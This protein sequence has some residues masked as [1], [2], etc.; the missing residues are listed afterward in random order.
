MKGLKNKFGK[1]YRLLVVLSLAL[2]LILG[3]ITYFIT[4]GDRV[5]DFSEDPEYLKSGVVD[6]KVYVND[7]ESTYNYYMGLNYTDNDGS[8]PT[9]VNK[10]KYTDNNLVQVKITYSSQDK[11]NHI[12]YVS[13]TERQDTFVYFKTFYVNDNG[14]SDKSD[15]YIEIMLIDNPFTDRPQNM[16]FNGW[17][18]SYPGLV[19]SYD[20]DYY[21]RY[22]KV[23]VT[24]DGD[25]PKKIDVSFNASWVVAKVG[26]VTSSFDSA[27]NSLYTIGMQ[28]VSTVITDYG[29]RYY[30]V[31]IS[32]YESY[33][34]YYNNRGVYQESG[35]CRNWNGCTYY[36]KITGDNY[37]DSKDYYELVNGYMTNRG[38]SSELTPNVTYISDYQNINMASFY[39]KVVIT[40]GSSYA[41]YYNSNGEYQNSGT[42]NSNS[43]EYYE[44][45]QYYDSDGNEEISKDGEEY[46]Y[47]VTRDTNILVLTQD[48]SGGWSNNGSY[49]FTITG[50]YNQRDYNVD[51]KVSSAIN[52][53]NDT[54][55]ENVT[56]YYPYN[57]SGTYNPPTNTNTAGVLYGRYNNVR[58]GRGI[59][60][61]GNYYTFRSI[62]FGNG[63]S[64][65]GSSNSPA[66]YRV[67]LESGFYNSLSLSNG[68]STNGRTTLYLN[69][70]TEYGNDYDRVLNNDSKLDVYYCASSVWS[71]GSVYATTRS[72]TTR[73][74][75]FDVVVKSGTFGRVRSDLTSGIYVGGRYGGT[76]Y[77][78]RQ[79]K[80]LG[81]KIF[82][83]IG[84][85]LSASQRASYN[86]IYIYMLGGTVDAIT[87][88]AGTSATYGNR[89]VQV[90]GG[91]VNYAIFGG[92]NGYDGSD[93]DGTLRGSSYVYVGG[94]AIIGNEENMSS[95]LYGAEAG[96]VFGI[97]N[98]NSAAP[99]IGSCDNSTVIIDGKA[100]VRGNVYGGGNYGATGISSTTDSSSTKIV[101]NN[102][103]VKGSVYG[104]GNKNGSGDTSKRATV[105]IKMYNGNVVGSI[106]GG[107]N[108]EG[109]IYGDVNLSVLGGEVGNSVYGGGRGGL[110]NNTTGTYVRNKINLVVGDIN[111]NYTPI[112]NGAVY[113]GSAFGTVNGVTNNTTVSADGTSVVINKGII[114]SVYG[115]GQGNSEYTPYVLGNIEVTVNDGKITS[116][117]GGNDKSGKPNGTIKVTINGGVIN[118]AFGGGNETSAN[119][120][121]VYLN[122]GVSSKI[123]GGSNKSGDVTASYVT[124]TGGN[125]TYIYGGNNQGG[126][127]GI[128]NVLITGGNIGAVFGGGDATSVNDSTNV[129]IK[130]RVGTVYGG[131]NLLGTVPVANINV[132]D[133]IVDDLYGG[134]NQ[135]GV[136]NTSNVNIYG[137]YLKNV[138]GGGNKATTEVTNINGYYGCVY[139]IYGGGMEAGATTTNINLGDLKVSNVYGGA[140]ISGVVSDA[141][142]KNLDSG[143]RNSVKLDISYGESSQHNSQATNYKSSQNI[144]VKINNQGSSSI[145]VWDLY[146][147]TSDG[148]VGSNWSSAKVLDIPDGYYID[149]T[150]QYYGTNVINANGELSFDFHIHSQVSYEDFM[151][152]GYYF[153]GYDSNN[154]KYTSSI[155]IGNI[156]GGNNEGGQTDN[157]HIELT[158]G[159]IGNIYGGGNKAL[160]LT[161]SVSVS[162]TE[163]TNN[164]FGG[165][166]EATVNTVDMVISGS[167]IGTEEVDGQ[168]YGG[169]NKATVNTSIKM[170]VND[171]TKVFGS[172]YGGGN[173]GSV[174]GAIEATISQSEVGKNVYGGGNEAPVTGNILLNVIDNSK[175]IDSVYGGGNLGVVNGTVTT[176]ITDSEITN[177]IYGAGNKATVGLATLDF[178][179]DMV[180]TNTKVTNIYGGGNAALT[181][182]NVNV[183]VINST[184]SGSIFG[185]G[186]GVDSIVTGD[187][188]GENNLAKVLGNTNVI[189]DENTSVNNIYGGGNLGMV[190]GNTNVRCGKIRVLD[191]IY[192]G[193]NAAIVGNDTYLL[194]SNS[195]VMNSV[196]AGG[197]GVTAKVWGNTKIDID[198]SSNITNHVFG[199][200]NAA[201]TG[202]EEKNNSTGVVNI[203]GANI[204]KNV[205][206]GANTSVLYGM[207]KVNIGKD[208]VTNSD[209][210][211]S[212]IVIGGTVFGGGEANAGGSEI[213]DFT[214]ISV[215]KGID[216]NIDGNGYSNFTIGGSIFG[217]GN[218]SSTSGDSYVNIYNYGNKDDVKRNISIQ[219]AS[220]VTL[221]NS[222]M[223]LSGAT[224]RTNEYSDVLFTLSRIDELKLINSSSIYL[225]KGA[226]LVKKFTSLA[227]VDGKQEKAVASI[228]NDTGTFSRNVN[229]RV[230]M[231]SGENLNIAKNENV[232]DYGD[233]TGMTFFGMYS[234]DRN[235]NIITALY[236]DYEYNQ[237]VSSGDI[238]YF[239][240]GSYVLGRHL[241][242]HNITVDG[243]YSNYGN[244][245]GDRIIIKYIEP[246][247]ADS[248]FYMWSIGEVIASYEV[249]LTASKFS[250]LGTQ[251]VPLLNHTSPNTTFSILGVN[252]SELDS[253][254][255]LIDYL[256]I[257]RVASSS[258]EANT[259]FGLT[260]KS[261]PVGWLT[262]G[263]TNFI[264]DGNTNVIGTKQYERE[265]YNNVPAFVFYLYHSKNLTTTGTMGSVTVSLVAITPIDDLN[266]DVERINININLSRA[267]YNTNDYEGTIAPGKKYEMFATSS[268]DIT[269][270]SSFS[271]YYSLY[272]NSDVSP[273]KSGYYRSLVSSIVFPI[274]TKITMI[275]LHNKNRPIY[276]YYVVNQDDYDQAMIEYNRYSEASYKLSRFVK[277]G[278]TSDDNNYN[279]EYYNE[280]YYNNKIAEEEFIFMV[281]F[282]NANISEDLM[283]NSLLIELRNADE[284][285]L[286]SVLG[287]EQQTLKYNLYANSEAVIE[288]EGSISKNPLYLG[289][290]T[291]MVIDTNFV[292]E[293]RGTNTVYDTTFD[294]EKLGIKISIFDSHNNLLSA[295]DLMGISFT[296]NGNKYY[297][298][299]DGTTRIKI[300][301]KVANARSRI[302]FDTGTSKIATGEY[303][304]LVE[305]FGSYDGVYYGPETSKKLEMK[306]NIIDSPYGLKVKSA[307]ESIFIDKDSGIVAASGNNMYV[308]RINYVSEL[309]NANL[310]VKLKR[311]NYDNIYTDLYDDVNLL[312]YISN[313]LSATSNKWEYVLTNSPLD[314][315][316][317]NYTFKE[318]LVT[319]TYKLV[320][321]LYD[322]NNYIGEV[323][324]YIIIK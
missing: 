43:C 208:V 172:V 70:M 93:G 202:T 303:T 183:K 151:I 13:L 158:R 1:K 60:K 11:A 109:T 205:Y 206:G 31:S 283:N 83:L 72:S 20:N 22:A 273:Y 64:N 190:S 245:D 120:T 74:V 66:K 29:D 63:N 97:G 122:G 307:G 153:V 191:S 40:R 311:R 232:T 320:V 192:G 104:G 127:T 17:I 314:D 222:Y 114:E 312:D 160:T 110:D 162:N 174:N 111:S 292:Q 123:F 88:G 117:Y 46:Y 6:N 216:I 309:E 200:G 106:Y 257:P 297:P 267:L 26:M 107:S 41:G 298:R 131:S 310:R 108:E 140:N 301:D 37:S 25:R 185:G 170:L 230:Y 224:D 272:I 128:T 39:R 50:V 226:N 96:S 323:Y 188:T 130:S 218:A 231:E 49:P 251:E 99:T 48:I 295:Q 180:V 255:K 275:D 308:F 142:I 51:W 27:I 233:V 246:T 38:S 5:I 187:E 28:Q 184:L 318:N 181:N 80:V 175:V 177:N 124:A 304:I 115:G 44:M 234:L 240:D 265:N 211:A 287:I 16:A 59:N 167:K 236:D 8:Y 223:L 244:D 100:I 145:N 193:G 217:S 277:M 98:G 152:Y 171:N 133:G 198:N 289:K 284:Q 199:G 73:E 315:V 62:V 76:Q 189:V 9:E 228:D 249:N 322:G 102:G 53:Y 319:G 78:V 214:F 7:L 279:D 113:G 18:S 134:N 258:D 182:N 225:R 10:N 71:G 95:L 52:C 250:T 56:M 209:L 42:C 19:L 215:T 212:D 235:G 195:V 261:G 121:Y 227:L 271:T 139:N 173:L 89:I 197:N 196:Y 126:T 252:F 278:S 157:T 300:S 65:A 242:N 61:S 150:N 137:S 256:D 75:I 281:D 164:I 14:T 159:L 135:G 221:D 90:T 178:A 94:D 299:Y 207:T 220:V 32:F 213:Y 91:T 23:P 36:E 269:T 296:Y 77:A 201:S 238:Y 34:G 33:A 241:V 4:Y 119:S 168:I 141:N 321:S 68:A 274:D 229:N 103:I 112:I 101:I 166:N 194:V 118:D 262:N 85:P 54:N 58:I 291:N 324:Q 138:Y 288:L 290:N 154:N 67:V 268:V 81:G 247:P 30:Q 147:L 79:I 47:L 87:G 12:G 260:M 219:R 254:I 203:A 204:G 161:S 21:L 280:V 239:T 179:T 35:T 55:I 15:D 305:S 270:K 132:E 45:I 57:V 165:G 86:D 302:L 155:N 2:V 148:F 264:T 82:N 293:K 316:V 156:Y 149:E 317:Y 253:N 143:V 313:S 237:E 116:L 3:N 144:K 282:K 84:G 210:I 125:A 24:Y 266:N 263:S 248:E 286:I 176:K 146:I 294:D 259:V 136:T 69:N 306:L 105:T 92:S 276:Y 129:T 285:T 163:V 243:F 169:G 186:N